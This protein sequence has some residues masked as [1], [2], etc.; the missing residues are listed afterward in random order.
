MIKFQIEFFTK[1]VGM[2]VIFSTNL[3][4]YNVELWNS[5]Y[6]Q[7]NKRRVETVLY[8]IDF[9]EYYNI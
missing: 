8:L 1:V 7:K 6:G 4:S 3:T 2:N 5:R 9:V